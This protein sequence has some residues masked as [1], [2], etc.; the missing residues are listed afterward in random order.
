MDEIQVINNLENNIINEKAKVDSLKNKPQNKFVSWIKD[1]QNRIFL[2]ILIGAI[3][4]RF[5]YFWLTKSQPLWWDESE[6]MSGAKSL[7]G[8]V[9]YDLGLTRSPL[10]PGM[11][12]IFFFLGIAN[13]AV[14]RFFG[15]LLPSVLVIILTYF[16]IKEMYDDK[17]IALL[18]TVIISVLWEHLFYSNRFHTEN[19]ALIFQF[20]ALFIFFR[21]YM[22]G[23]DLLF[24]K[25]KYALWWV[26][27]FSIISFLFRPGNILFVPALLLFF[28]LLN[29]N[30]IFTKKGLIGLG[31]LILVIIASFIFTSIPQNF[32]N[33]YLHSDSP[34]GWNGLT[35]FYGFY[36]SII[37]QIPSI[38]FYAFIIGL[39]LV[40][41]KIFL[42]ADKIKTMNRSN[43]NLEFKSD[44]FNLILIVVVL[45]VFIFLMRANSFEYRWFFPLLPG[46]LAFTS[47]GIVSFSEYVGGFV[48]SKV[49]VNALIILIILLGAYTQFAHADSIIK[50]KVDS[51]SQLKEAGLWLN[52]NY[53][54]S[55][56]ILSVS[57]A[58]TTYYSELNVSSFSGIDNASVFDSYLAINRPRFMEISGFETHPSW[59][60]DWISNN[61]NRTTPIKVYYVDI[62][63]QQPILVIFEISYSK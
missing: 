57:S 16:M 58:Q 23:K 51:Y 3:V 11:M 52:E 28:I 42:L 61:K 14:M 35:V 15:L 36:Q 20:L 29:K 41:F 48:K 38:L 37:S 5:Y 24:I 55:E 27:G 12:S 43:E 26:V 33:A 6:Y 50:S 47:K 25:P 34:F 30:K 9:H 4:L 10:F 31:I 62:E 32:L 54:H 60:N 63:K 13:E 46:M 17:R 59:L 45:F 21:C 8:L 44:L 49:F 22:K 53:N 39:V 18:S 1:P 7:A 56:K 19:S 2:L 40:L